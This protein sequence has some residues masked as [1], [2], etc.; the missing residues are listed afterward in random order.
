MQHS[1]R[2]SSSGSSKPYDIGSLSTHYPSTPLHHAFWFFFLHDLPFQIYKLSS[3]IFLFWTVCMLTAISSFIF[4]V[5]SFYFPVTLGLDQMTACDIN[6]PDQ[7][8]VGLSSALRQEE[9]LCTPG[10]HIRCLTG[11]ATGRI[12]KSSWSQKL[13]RENKSYLKY[14][15]S[16]INLWLSPSLHSHYSY[17]VDKFQGLFF[18]YK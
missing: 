14:L 15:M 5:V 1:L 10:T 9:S 2:P 7:P 17:H 13:E 11:F 12:K 4:K 16:Y 8:S 3:C 18:M 6:S